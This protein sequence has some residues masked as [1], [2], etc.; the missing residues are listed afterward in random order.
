MPSSSG[1]EFGEV[2]EHLIG[3]G[4][5]GG[6]K[7]HGGGDAHKARVDVMAKKKTTGKG[8]KGKGGKGKKGGKGQ[9]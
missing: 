8:A 5:G 9:G 6:H 3:H 4:H 7:G 2:V 1:E